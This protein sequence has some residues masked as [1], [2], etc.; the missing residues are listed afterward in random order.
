M[1]TEKRKPH[2]AQAD[3]TP[4]TSLP[5][6]LLELVNNATV[7]DLRGPQPAAETLKGN[8]STPGAWGESPATIKFSAAGGRRL[9]KVARLAGK[10]DTKVTRVHARFIGNSN[11]ILIK[12]ADALDLTAIE[13]NYY[14]GLPG[15]AVNLYD[16]LAPANA[17]IETRYRQRYDVHFVPK[18][19]PL[20][21]GL[22]IDL[23][24]PK[25]RR[26]MPLRK[27]KKKAPQAPPKE[28]TGN[29]GT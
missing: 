23:D 19:S 20:Y 14:K 9:T 13:V 27:R 3:Q 8:T 22:L 6:K 11:T 26:L 7:E 4:D 21:P 10:P 25:D 17:T 2:E 1:T 5:D 12:A 29:E 15:G 16:L 24:D 28:P 18:S